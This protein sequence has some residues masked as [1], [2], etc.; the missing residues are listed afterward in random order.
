MKKIKTNTDPTTKD[1][2]HSSL[3]QFKNPV[4]TIRTEKYLIRI[5]ELANG[6]YRYA[7]WKIG[8]KENA[9]P[10]IIINNGELEFG[11]SGGIT[12][13]HSQ[14]ETILTKYI[15]ILL[16]KKMRLILPLM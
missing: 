5:D 6:K 4:Y 10:D 8:N 16:P 14:T 7:S 13:L 9:Q 11:G 12:S 3:K 1:Y 15:G 2:V